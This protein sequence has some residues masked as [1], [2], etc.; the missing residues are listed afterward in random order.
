[1]GHV[2]SGGLMVLSLDREFLRDTLV[3]LAVYVPSG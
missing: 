2:K 1:M 3:L